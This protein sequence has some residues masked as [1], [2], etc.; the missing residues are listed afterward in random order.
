MKPIKRTSPVKPNPAICQLDSNRDLSDPITYPNALSKIKLLVGELQ[1]SRV[2]VE[3]DYHT[4]TNNLTNYTGPIVV[5]IPE[6]HWDKPE[7]K[8]MKIQTLMSLCSDPILKIDKCP[9]EFFRIGNYFNE[10]EIISLDIL[11]NHKTVNV[12][13]ALRYLQSELPHKVSL[14]PTEVLSL[15]VLMGVS[16]LMQSELAG[17]YSQR[18]YLAGRIAAELYNPD[19]LIFES[20]V[21]EYNNFMKT[22]LN[23]CKL[24]EVFELRSIRDSKYDK[25]ISIP[26]KK[27]DL[28][29]LKDFAD[30]SFLFVMS[31]RSKAMAEVLKG[32]KGVLPFVIGPEHALNMTVM[33][34]EPEVPVI[35]LK[36]KTSD[37]TVNEV[38]T[39]LNTPIK[40]AT[41]KGDLQ[42][43]SAKYRSFIADGYPDLTKLRFSNAE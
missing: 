19:P 36:V 9:I 31:E 38:G 33:N 8:K 4:P 3:I 5:F 39:V 11:A 1:S 14:I 32:L 18:E 42:T 16:M 29:E 37:T 15:R 13:Y 7:I 23:N 12:A 17:D 41:Y 43:T 10:D 28:E 26:A 24:Q 40:R 20:N 25:D 2:N 34:L 6:D 27:V 35:V 21:R 30:T 22:L